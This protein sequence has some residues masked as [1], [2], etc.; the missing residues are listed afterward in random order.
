V[1]HC[2]KAPNFP[3]KVRLTL[4]ILPARQLAMGAGAMDPPEA[5][6][7]LPVDVSKGAA[8]DDSKDVES[9]RSVVVAETARVTDHV[10]ERKL[11]WKFDIRILPFLAFMCKTT[12][13][14]TKLAARWAVLTEPRPLQ[15][16]GQGKPRQCPDSWP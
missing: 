13:L 16:S 2:W 15:R 12:A 11:C 8:D 3:L 10:A 14:A 6:K 1:L 4:G 9:S 7:P 5:Q